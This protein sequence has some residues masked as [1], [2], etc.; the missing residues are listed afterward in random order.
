MLGVSPLSITYSF[1]EIGDNEEGNK[2]L[3]AILTEEIVDGKLIV[4]H[5]ALT[6][7]LSEED[8]KRKLSFDSQTSWAY[9]NYDVYNSGIVLF[10]GK[11]SKIGDNLWDISTDENIS[12]DLSFKVVFSEKNAEIDEESLFA[13]SLMNSMMKHPEMTQDIKLL[14]T[15]EM[16]INSEKPI[17]INQ[18]F[19]DSISVK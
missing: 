19:R 8:Y 2:E 11:A 17:G 9:V 10:D 12:E 14:H 16:V 13:L 1:A 18:E 15:G 6:N 4:S 7:E 5:Y 3:G